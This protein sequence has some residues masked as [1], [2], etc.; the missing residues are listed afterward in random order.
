MKFGVTRMRIFVT[1]LNLKVNNLAF[2][3]VPVEAVVAKKGTLTKPKD[4]LKQA[5]NSYSFKR[6]KAEDGCIPQK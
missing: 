5:Q 1:G 3:E 2:K 4:K 6:I